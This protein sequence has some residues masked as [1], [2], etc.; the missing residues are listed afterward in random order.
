LPPA[1]ICGPL[2]GRLVYLPGARPEGAAEIYQHTEE[3]T[4]ILGVAIEIEFA[5]GIPDCSAAR[6]SIPDRDT[7]TD[8]GPAISDHMAL[9]CP[10]EC[11]R[12]AIDTFLGLAYDRL[13]SGHNLPLL[14]PLRPVWDP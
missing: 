10:P 14:R 12:R 13:A 7:D 4:V 5:V 1:I 8:A 2:Q 3:A 11:H 6:N 9:G